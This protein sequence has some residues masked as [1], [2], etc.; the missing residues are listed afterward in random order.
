MVLSKVEGEHHALGRALLLLEF[1]MVKF[2]E[3]SLRVFLDTWEIYLFS[4]GAAL[5]L[6][7]FG[8]G[9]VVPRFDLQTTLYVGVWIAVMYSVV[10]E[11]VRHY[12]EE[13][14]TAR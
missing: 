5:L 14:L 9:G 2:L 13:R 3:F 1:Q 4:I 11:T 10:Y 8:L 7:A 6:W 12:L